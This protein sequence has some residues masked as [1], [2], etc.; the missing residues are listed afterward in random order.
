VARVPIWGVVASAAAPVLL[1]GGWT[2]AAALQ[3]R[4]FDSVSTTISALAGRDAS[5]RWVM[6]AAILATGLCQLL[7]A[8]ALRPARLAGRVVLFVGGLCTCLVA[9]NPLPPAPQA[10]TGHAVFATG[11]FLCLA[12][13]PLASWRA[14]HDVSWALRRA[15]AV[16]AG[17]LLV[18]LTAWFFV[19]SLTDSDLLGLAERAAAGTQ[20]VWPFVVTLGAWRQTR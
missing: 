7:T 9:L 18:S 19:A 17:C 12:A 4:A 2:L 20:N 10:S 15:V 16:T 11:T 8:F 14:G 3:P 6:T 13:W 1:I 5:H